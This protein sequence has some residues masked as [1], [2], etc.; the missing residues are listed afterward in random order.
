MIT[1]V[2]CC[3]CAGIMAA[4]M[5]F[6]VRCRRRLFLNLRWKLKLWI[7]VWV[8]QGGRAEG[9]VALGPQLLKLVLFSLVYGE[10]RA[11]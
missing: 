8:R 3:N 9:C 1:A 11:F 7:R 2:I 5:A 6:G 4:S 10:R